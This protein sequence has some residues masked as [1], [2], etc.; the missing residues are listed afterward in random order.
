MCINVHRGNDVNVIFYNTICRRV[1]KTHL[2]YKD[3]EDISLDV[4]GTSIVCSS[5]FGLETGAGHLVDDEGGL[6]GGSGGVVEGISPSVCWT[7]HSVILGSFCIFLAKVKPSFNKVLMLF[8]CFKQ[9]QTKRVISVIIKVP[10]MT[11]PPG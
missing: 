6:G 4:V 8:L 7:R 3:G 1:E 2:E 9:N 11:L 10:D 5:V